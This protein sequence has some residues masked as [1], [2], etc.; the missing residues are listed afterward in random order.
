MKRLICLLAA[1]LISVSLL[2]GKKSQ[3]CYTLE[4]P[5]TQTIATEPTQPEET[6]RPME[7]EPNFQGD[8]F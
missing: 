1:L 4:N 2:I 3:I 8:D 5:P 6:F 7:E